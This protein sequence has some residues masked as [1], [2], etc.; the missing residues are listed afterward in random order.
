MKKLREKAFEEFKRKWLMR[1][2]RMVDELVSYN[3]HKES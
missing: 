2:N 1:K 3:Y